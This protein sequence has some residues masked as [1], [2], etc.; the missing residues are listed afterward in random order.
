MA[1]WSN[2]KAWDE[3][4]AELRPIGGGAQAAAKLVM[5][6]TTKSVGFA[7]ILNRQSVTERRS[8]FF[9]EATAHATA[10]HE[11]IPRLIESNS[12][13]Y[14]DLQYRLYLITEFI[15]GQTLREHILAH[16]ALPFEIAS[17]QMIRLIQ[18]IHY[19]HSNEW[20]H[21]DIK[22]DNII[23]RKSNPQDP[24]LLDF[25]ICYKSEVTDGFETDYAQELGNR[26]LRLPEM[27]AGSTAK[28]DK[29]TDVAF[30]GGILYY[31]MTATSPS[32]LVDED[33]RMPHQRA[34]SAALLKNAFPKHLPALLDFFDKSFSQSLSGRFATV[35]DMLKGLERLV[36]L[37]RE[38]A[39]DQSETTIED[40]LSYL[41]TKVNS[42]L[43]RNKR[44]YDLGMNVIRK[45]H[46]TIAQRIAPTYVS[47]QTGYVNFVDGLRNVMG[48]SHFATQEHRFAPSFL[49]KVVGSEVV[50]FADDVCIYRTDVEAPVFSERLEN[51]V[52][53][54]YL[55]G[56]K[57]LVEATPAQ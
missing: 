42:D 11:G 41:D 13:H 27:S 53:R 45:V 19:L 48:F 56:L 8:R 10:L 22:P 9:R 20:I 40:V 54:I 7:K 23:L 38:T 2:S 46:S 16:G 25:G 50:V 29:R 43:A 44:L 3:S 18:I 4:W 55:S 36:E 17:S 15:E 12:Q 39:R 49:I 28:Q 52:E 47:F 24:V 6:I 21:R 57:R 30:L 31:A 26:F 14:D 5:N 1:E 32:V 33:G 51:A 37:H 35:T 34:N